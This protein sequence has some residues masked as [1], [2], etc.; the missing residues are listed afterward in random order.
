[1]ASKDAKGNVTRTSEVTWGT[2]NP[3]DG[4]TGGGVSAVE[5][6]PAYQQ[7]ITWVKGL[8]PGTKGRI[9][10][11]IAADASPRT[12]VEVPTSLGTAGVGG[13]SFS[14]PLFYAMTRQLSEASGKDIGFINTQLY[15]WGQDPVVAKKVFFDITQ[16]DNGMGKPGY[17]AGPG[18][19]AVTGWGSPNFQGMLDELKN[20]STSLVRSALFGLKGSALRTAHTALTNPMDLVTLPKGW[21]G[22]DNTNK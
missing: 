13:T 5:D 11:D 1:L 22:Q 19:D 16:G 14:N 7:F 10:P 3:K 20:P 6:R 18:Y 15:K 9:V 21:N 4:A 8:V 17:H 12:P 2:A